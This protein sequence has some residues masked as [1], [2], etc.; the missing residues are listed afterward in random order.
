MK[1]ETFFLCGFVVSVFA[2][3]LST[4]WLI[5]AVVERRMARRI[6]VDKDEKE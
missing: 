4:A 2:F 3:L 6:G 5:G 1:N